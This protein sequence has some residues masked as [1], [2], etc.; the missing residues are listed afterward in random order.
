M[1]RPAHAR[2]KRETELGTEVQCSA[3]NEFWPCDGEFFY[4]TKGVPH[5]W[6][7]ACYLASPAQIAKKQRWAEKQKQLRAGPAWPVPQGV[8]A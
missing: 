4:M 8:S 1:T 6:C 2:G 5:S 7:K 3:C